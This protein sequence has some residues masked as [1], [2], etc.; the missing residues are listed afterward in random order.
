M[1]MSGSDDEKLNKLGAP[2]YKLDLI[3]YQ[4]SADSVLGVP[5]NI[6]SYA[7]LLQMMAKVTG[8]APGNFYYLTGDTHIYKNHFDAVQEQ[9]NRKP[10]INSTRFIINPKIKTLLDLERAKPNDFRVFNYQ[11]LGNLNHETPMAV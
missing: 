3:M 6:T 1:A 4:R 10:L 9:I 7:M 5:F 8:H 2:K 11:N